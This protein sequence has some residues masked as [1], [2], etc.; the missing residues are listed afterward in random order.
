MKID[1]VVPNVE[2][3]FLRLISK[4]EEMR[5]PLIMILRIFFRNFVFKKRIIPIIIF[6]CKNCNI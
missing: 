3:K 6:R 4:L 5:I 1:I 2:K